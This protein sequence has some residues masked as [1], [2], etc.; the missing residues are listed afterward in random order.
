MFGPAGGNSHAVDEYI[1]LESTFD[2]AESLLLFIMEWC[3]V[4]DE[5]FD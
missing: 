4:D 5:Y 1:D 2:F 3:G